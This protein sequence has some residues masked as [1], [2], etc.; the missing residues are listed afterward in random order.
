M[1]KDGVI[2]LLLSRIAK[3]EYEVERLDKQIE[4]Y[5]KALD[6]TTSK[7]ID[8]EKENNLLKQIIGNDK[9]YSYG[10]RTGSDKT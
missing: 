7:K 2:N 9:N 8:L 1:N 6:E 5:Q 3:L 10:I 4:E